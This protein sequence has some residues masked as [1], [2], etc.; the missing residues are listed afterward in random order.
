MGSDPRIWVVLRLLVDSPAAEE[1]PW[2]S[3]TDSTGGR[4]MPPTSLEGL[5]PGNGWRQ[6]EIGGSAGPPLQIF[7][8]VDLEGEV[9]GLIDQLPRIEGPHVVGPSLVPIFVDLPTAALADWGQPMLEFAAGLPRA[10]PVTIA[11]SDEWAPRA[12]FRLPFRI[13]VS[14]S[15]TEAVNELRQSNWIRGLGDREPYA[16]V[17]DVS[18]REE[19][20]ARL[21]GG[22]YDI[23]IADAEDLFDVVTA[24]S[25]VNLARRPRLVVAVTRRSPDAYEYLRRRSVDE[26]RVRDIPPGCSFLGL[27]ARD[28]PRLLVELVRTF[29]HDLPLHDAVAEIC[30]AADL[31]WRDVRLVSDPVANHA[32]RISDAQGW[33]QRDAL[34]LDWFSSLRHADSFLERVGPSADVLKSRLQRAARLGEE[35]IAATDK[36]R[37]SAEVTYGQESEGLYPL[38]EN[39][40]ELI[41]TTGQ[42]QDVVEILRELADDP[43]AASVLREHQE[44]RVDIA[45]AS[46]TPLQLLPRD[47]VLAANRVYYVFVRIGGDFHRSLFAERPPAIDPL[48]PDPIDAQGHR[49]EIVLYP[50]DFELRPPS[51]QQVILPLYGAT[52]VAQFIVETP[53]V[54]DGHRTANARV[55][56][57]HDNHLIQ[58]FLLRADVAPQETWAS[59]ALRVEL[60]FSRTERFENVE[61]LAPRAASLAINQTGGASHRLMIKGDGTAQDFLFSEEM[62]EK[63]IESFRAT[64]EEATAIT[65]DVPRFES[66][67]APGTAKRAE[68]DDYIRRLAREGA[69]L[70]E[71]LRD[72]SNG[73][74]FEALRSVAKKRD[75]TIQIIRYDPNYALPW[76]A[77]YDFELPDGDAPVCLGTTGEG[78]ICSHAPMESLDVFCVYGFWGVRHHIEQ[79]LVPPDGNASTPPVL[80][81]PASADPPTLVALGVDDAYTRALVD[82]LERFG[83]KFVEV[84]GNKDV[85]TLVW[86]KKTRPT[87]LVVVGHLDDASNLPR[88]LLP[89]N[90]IIDGSAI[91]KRAWKTGRLEDPRP[92]VLL[93]ACGST[94]TDLATHAGLSLAASSAGAAA[95]IGTEATVFTGLV[96]QFVCE[97]M[98]ELWAGRSMGA[99]VT[100][101]RRQLLGRGN[102]LAFVF[103][104]F[105]DADLTVSHP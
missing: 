62:L 12:P 40:L 74:L 31:G 34:E 36:I 11:R 103:T 23:A 90:Q 30:R 4:N 89:N 1:G 60:E 80:V 8:P 10:W 83:P 82:G 105:G 15:A 19:L 51:V 104:P 52:P 44:R 43:E 53:F 41:S 35:V 88:I 54:R 92:L 55:C 22:A 28:D 45:V 57:Y 86:D 26:G 14:G 25:H 91:G 42:R 99:A 5:F 94:A 56:I 77:F 7:V 3:Y 84:A 9:S 72:R 16:I 61:R 79:F 18:S 64:L 97:V 47:L 2:L 59:D 21:A 32:L 101:F 39:E 68:A 13:I 95:V 100:S 37:Y 96:Q 73:A 69:K 17:F 85:L 98:E 6:S 93:M 49:I 27:P 78:E 75:Q 33:L 38:A 58:S 63:D 50:I 29:V 65:P 24:T 20:P 102:P 67:P 87:F 71:E 70:H 48:L 66:D 81:A 76:A 46:S